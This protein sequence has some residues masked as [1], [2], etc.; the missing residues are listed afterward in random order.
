MAIKMGGII[1][2]CCRVILRSPQLKEDFLLYVGKIHVCKKND[3]K[4]QNFIRSVPKNRL[5]LL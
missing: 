3:K 1:C 2:D 5:M 4:H